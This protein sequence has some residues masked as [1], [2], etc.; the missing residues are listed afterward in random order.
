ME[1]QPVLLNIF[2]LSQW[3]VLQLLLHVHTT[4]WQHTEL[5]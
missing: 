5:L 3:Q 4:L 2:N 1:P